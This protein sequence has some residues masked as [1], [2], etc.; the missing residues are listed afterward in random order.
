MASSMFTRPS[1]YLLGTSRE[2]FTVVGFQAVSQT[3]N[4]VWPLHNLT[5]EERESIK[6]SPL[7]GNTSIRRNL[8]FIR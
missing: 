7:V 3:S 2:S 1:T 4:S 6:V 8:V 5:A